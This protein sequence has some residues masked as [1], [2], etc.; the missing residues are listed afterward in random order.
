MLDGVNSAQ[1]MS[2]E[3]SLAVKHKD[4]ERTYQ[5]YIVLHAPTLYTCLCVADFNSPSI[6]EIVGYITILAKF[7]HIYS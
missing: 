2:C 3:E 1:K 7:D 6:V 4:Y 5:C